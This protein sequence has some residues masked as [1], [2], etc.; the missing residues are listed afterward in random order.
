M[1]LRYFVSGAWEPDAS[2]AVD[3]YNKRLGYLHALKSD[4]ERISYEN[5]R[6]PHSG[7]F[8]IETKAFVPLGEL[9]EQILNEE[10]MLEEEQARLNKCRTDGK[11]NASK[12][13]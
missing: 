10:I 13:A 9:R 11:S 6:A 1:E 8:F 7:L 4:L 2:R 3:T 12:G 5:A